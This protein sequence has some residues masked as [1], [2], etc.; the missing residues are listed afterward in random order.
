MHLLYNLGIYSYGLLIKL[1]SPFNPKAK[2]WLNGRKDFFKNLPP[3]SNDN[4]YWFHC[5]SL[6]EFD[7][8]LPVINL[9]KSSN[10]SIFV[11]VTFFSPSGYLHFHKRNHKADYVCYLPLDTQNN[12]EKFIK[13]FN[14]VK[15]F[16]VKYEFWANYIFEL[17]KTK[18]EL[19]SISAIFRPDQR[20]FKKNNAFFKSILYKFDHFFI[21]NEI[22]AELLKSIGITNFDITGDTRFDRVIENKN[23]LTKNE[24]LDQFSNGQKT[25]ILGSSWT[26]DEKLIIPLINKESWTQKVIIAPHDI[27]ENHINEI[28]KLL[29]TPFIR[30]SN[31]EKGMK[32]NNEKVLILDTIGHLANAYSYGEVAYVGGGFSGSLHNILEPA[33]FG[34]P[35]IFGPKHSRFPEGEMFINEGIGFSITTESEFQEKYTL[36]TKNIKDLKAKT[37]KFIQLQTGASEKIVSFLN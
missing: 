25:V 4:V 20:F 22:S 33:V 18:A 16:F 26:I 23:N 8:A 9:I 37:E 10:P 13:Y 14:P 30:Y 35:V 15:A 5:A 27:S 32:Y 34:L 3:I 31:L 17:K 28:L 12:A 1:I 19:Y 11:L 24:I 29:Q 21:Q 6:G 2:L 7:Q 36:I